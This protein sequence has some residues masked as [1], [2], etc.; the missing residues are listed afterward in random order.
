MKLLSGTIMATF[1]L[2]AEVAAEWLR[3]F[4]YA[5]FQIGLGA[6]L[7]AGGGFSIPA[8]YA[9]PENVHIFILTRILIWLFLA[10]GVAL[11]VWG[12]VERKKAVAQG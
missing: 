4:F 5:V 12:L 11:I 9:T 2:M 7:Q 10:F 6:R 1:S 3:H 8:P